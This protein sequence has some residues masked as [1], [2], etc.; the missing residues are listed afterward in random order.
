VQIVL[1][2]RIPSRRLRAA[3]FAFP[4]LVA[5]LTLT[6]CEKPEQ[7]AIRELE[8]QNLNFTPEDFVA[9]AARGDQEAVGRFLIAGINVDEANA[10]GLTALIQAAE[11][12]HAEVVQQLLGAGANPDKGTP[13]NWTAL[14]AAADQN[15]AGIVGSLL[16]AHADVSIADANGWT[17]L[18]KAVYAGNTESVQKLAPYSKAEA[19]RALMLASLKN[20]HEIIP[21]LVENGADVNGRTEEKQTPLMFAAMKGNQEAAAALLQS[22]ADPS[23]VDGTGSSADVLALQRGFGELSVMIVDARN[24]VGEYKPV[25]VEEEASPTPTATPDPALANTT[26]EIDPTDPA[27]PANPTDPVDPTTSS[28]V[29]GVSD[30]PDASLPQEPVTDDNPL[31][32]IYPDSQDPASQDPASQDPATTP[33]ASLDDTGLTG[34]VF[35][36]YREEPVPFILTGVQGDTATVAMTDGSN[37]QLQVR[38]GDRVP[39]TSYRI[40]TLS[41]KSISSK[42]G[43]QDDVSEAVL[44]HVPSS[45]SFTMIKDIQA[46]AP[47]TSGQIEEVASASV[48]TVRHGDDIEIP[49]KGRFRVLDLNREQVMLESLDNSEVYVLKRQ[50]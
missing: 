49:G 21:V 29:V 5:L 36:E 40:E 13:D 19:D 41:S 4:V 34:V 47:T 15:H 31:T 28:A 32:T 50:P 17:A 2:R 27:D 9:S 37:E 20:H 3:L 43:A 12:G 42:E 45:Q 18:M 25:G 14:M 26:P 35:R 30:T 46:Y 7:K 10:Q 44:F 16:D 48:L 38:Q 39:G 22:G 8:E 23:A 6:G 1:S 11:R 33:V 24:N